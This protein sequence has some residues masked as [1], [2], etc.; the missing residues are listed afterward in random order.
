[1]F[2]EKR[3]GKSWYIRWICFLFEIT[4]DIILKK[5]KM[6]DE[7]FICEF[8]GA[9]FNR[10]FNR[11]RHIESYHG[12]TLQVVES[13]KICNA[14]F[15]LNSELVHHIKNVHQAKQIFQVTE[16]A[17]KRSFV[18]YQ[19]QFAGNA[20][21]MARSQVSIIGPI[22]DTIVY[23]ASRQTIV[24][25]SLVLIAEM[26]MVGSEG[27]IVAKTSIPFRSPHF[28][29]N[30]VSKK[31]ISTNIVKS[32]N[33][34][35]QHM[36]SFIQSGSNWVFNRCLLFNLEI[37]PL[38]P[39]KGGSNKDQKID[40]STW[41][42]QRFL[43]NPC[44]EDEK[45]FL[46]C[47]AYAIW[48]EE[49]TKKTGTK[50]LNAKLKKLI[51]TKFNFKKMSF[52]SEIRDIE[53][54]LRQN[55]KLNLKINLLYRNLNNLIYP[56]EFGL[57]NGTKIINLLMVEKKLEDDILG[58]HF[59][60][61]KDVNKYLRN[62]YT[63]NYSKSYEQK[64]FC[65]NCLN[66]FSRQKTLDEHLSKCCMYKPRKERCVTDDSRI[67]QFKKFKA[68]YPQEM[69]GYL[70][71]ESVLPKNSDDVCETCTSL[72]CKCDRSYTNI[73]TQQVP[74]GYSL[75][76]L[77]EDEIVHTNTYMGEDPAEHLIEHLAEQQDAWIKDELDKN[78][79]MNFTSEDR[80]KFEES[81][82]C[83][84]CDEDF[85]DTRCKCRDHD[86]NTGRFI[87]AACTVCNLQ[88]QRP[89]PLKIF[90]HNGSRYDF[91][92][93]VKALKGRKDLEPIRVLPYNSEHFRTVE[94][95]CYMFNDSLA[96]LQAPLAQ[97][98]NDLFESDHDYPI[99]QQIKW[100]K[101]SNGEVDDKKLEMVLKKSFFPYEY[102]TSLKKMEKTRKLPCKESFYSSLSEK[103]ISDNDHRFAKRVWKKFNCKN[104][105]DYAKLY[106]RIDVLLLAE[107][108]QQFRRDMFKF[109][110]LDPAF[111]I[112]LPGYSF[113]SMLK[114]T[115]VRIELPQDINMVHFTESGIRG[116]MSVINTRVLEPCDEPGKE[117][118]IVY[119]DANVRI[120]FFNLNSVIKNFLNETSIF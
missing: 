84:I 36:D 20:I 56:L 23:E 3:E 70:D 71:F 112:S 113:D 93:I 39:L 119:I 25:A 10:Y 117:T 114:L 22:R 53:K 27:D 65:L 76:I 63:T 60:F 109:S 31:N 55:P 30:A 90:V 52:P 94:F 4:F 78:L 9:I 100:L 80:K 13:C 79:E 42:N 19:F 32:F 72:K 74:I 111:Y 48:G 103:T 107:I 2:G 115:K 51:Y 105:V 66:S 120:I 21:D 62:V 58:F 33:A 104:L 29:A 73:L 43:Y 99:L 45:C 108:F 81:S 110:G 41:E 118:E 40:I 14:T 96:F 11:Q 75:V 98:S 54:F 91:H 86:H 5:E 49:I 50:N 83:Y 77:C 8:C 38:K 102:C 34:Q 37:A 24:R 69:I 92:F 17:F 68:C 116:G 16:S 101:D 7:K 97:L 87:G 61:V 67:I 89:V 6:S 44:N 95:G 46:Y 85:N 59:I 18:N 47:V 64:F 106:C 82:K 26:I 88:R 35:R 28:L 57:G 15:L 12:G 1:M